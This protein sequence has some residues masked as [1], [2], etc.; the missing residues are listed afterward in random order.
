MASIFGLRKKIFLAGNLELCSCRTTVGA[1]V[2]GSRIEWNP[3]TYVRRNSRIYAR[4]NLRTRRQ[5]IFEN[6]TSSSKSRESLYACPRTPFIGRRRDFYIPR[7]PSNLENIPSVNMYMNVFYIP[8]FTG[9]ISYIYKPTTS[10]HF[11]S[12]LLRWHIWL[13]LSLTSEA[14]LVKIIT[15]Q[16]SRN[17]TPQDSRNSQ[18]PDLLNFRQIP[19][20]LK[21]TTDPRT[22]SQFGYYLRT[23]F[24]G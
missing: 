12:G 24:E 19:I 15:Y 14:L 11:K 20:T 8:R 5:E 21:Q 22:K 16:D 1:N 23:T 2:G 7:L 13:G 6:L 18:V 4:K 17:E 10:S 9:L 3:R